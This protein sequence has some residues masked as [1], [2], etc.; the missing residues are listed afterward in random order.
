MFLSRFRQIY[1]LYRSY[2][3]PSE[4]T[5]QVLKCESATISFN[6]TSDEPTIAS[7]ETLDALK[8]AARHLVD[9]GQTVVFPTETVYGLGALALDASCAAKIFSTKGRP[10]D[11]PLIVHVSSFSMLN[12]LL[13]PNYDVPK[14]YK[15]LM[16]HFWP[17][18]L[19][20]LFPR[21][22]DV[23]PT[24]ITANQST[25]A[26]RM[27]SHP[28]ARALIAVANAPL[29]APSANTSGKPSPTKAE[30]VFRDLNGKVPLILDGGACGVGLESTVVDGLHEDGNIRVL[31][32]GGITVEDLER[33]LREDMHDVGNIPKVLVHKRDYADEKMERAP[34]TPGMKYRHYSPSVPVTLLLTMPSLS[35]SQATQPFTE[36]LK[37]LKKE[38]GE[39]PM[40]IGVL[41]ATD[42]KLWETLDAVHGVDWTRFPL[43]LTEDPGT[44]AQ[45]LFD[46]LLSLEEDGVQMMFI[47]EVEET[48]EGLAIM[49]RVRK[50]ASESIRVTID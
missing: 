16:K 38:S 28:V 35:G 3:A 40:K 25:V 26:I 31:R 37:T 48:R 47:E 33:V 34:T 2:M 36:L 45:R 4:F 9:E 18:A 27:P 30:H 20:L 17:G 43:G 19:T 22:G 8:A 32:P 39:Q 24:I 5:T 14:S 44:I 15:I 21:N 10:A 11:N 1:A 50:A 41:A 12:S 49:N 46:G 6:T 7:A 23:I 13:P 42:S 29:A